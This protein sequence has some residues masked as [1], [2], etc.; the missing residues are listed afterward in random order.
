MGTQWNCINNAVL[1]SIHIVMY[2]KSKNKI[3]TSL[4]NKMAFEGTKSPGCVSVIM[5]R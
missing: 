1:T 5:R 2:V 3:N 4:V